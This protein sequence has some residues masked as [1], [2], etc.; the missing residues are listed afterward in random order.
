MPYDSSSTETHINHIHSVPYMQDQNALPYMQDQNANWQSYGSQTSS[1]GNCNQ[2]TDEGV[3]LEES[4]ESSKG[5]RNW[6]Y[7]TRLLWCVACL[8]CA[9]DLMTYRY[10]LDII[11]FVMI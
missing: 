10:S 6:L 4:K 1:Y 2:Q 8:V 9:A 5:K 11:N 7:D 3:Q